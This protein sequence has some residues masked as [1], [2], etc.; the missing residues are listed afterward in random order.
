MHASTFEI[1]ARQELRIAALVQ[2]VSQKSND[3]MSCMSLTKVAL[4]VTQHQQLL[5]VNFARHVDQ[6]LKRGHQL[7]WRPHLAGVVD[8]ALHQQHADKRGAHAAEPEDEGKVQIELVPE[9]EGQ[10]R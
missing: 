10:G 1:L 7:G 3:D 9:A 6:L 8:D 5:R 2:W 4:V